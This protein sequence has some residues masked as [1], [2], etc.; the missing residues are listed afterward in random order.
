MQSAQPVVHRFVLWVPALFF[1]SVHAHSK[2][3]WL[4]LSL[5]SFSRLLA[6]NSE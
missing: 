2:P 4:S 5:A 6:I 3:H 1:G